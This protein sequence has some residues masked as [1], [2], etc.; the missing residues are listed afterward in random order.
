MHLGGIG[1]ESRVAHDYLY[2][3]FSVLLSPPVPVQGY[4]LRAQR[5]PFTSFY[6]SISSDYPSLGCCMA[7]D[8][9]SVVKQTVYN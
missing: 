6:S 9:L 4:H 3:V 2:G 5:F 8:T 7:C 1:F